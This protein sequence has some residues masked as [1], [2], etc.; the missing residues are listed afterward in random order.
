MNEG[1][2][3]DVDVAMSIENNF[4]KFNMRSNDKLNVQDLLLDSIQQKIEQNK[5]RR[6][7]S[8]L[9]DY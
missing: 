2:V 5:Q 4:S 8:N 3:C 9:V 6:V 7:L 1:V